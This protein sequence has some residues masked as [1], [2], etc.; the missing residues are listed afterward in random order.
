MTLGVQRIP[1][2]QFYGPNGV[3]AETFGIIPSR[4]P[5]LKKKLGDFVESEV[6]INTGILK[7]YIHEPAEVLDGGNSSGSSSSSRSVGVTSYL[8]T[9][10]TNS[11]TGG[12]GMTSYL[13]T[14]GGK[15]H[16][17]F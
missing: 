9:L 8:D 5:F 2:I 6:D 17:G 14:I 15:A 12:T 4:M 7:N 13:D 10:T 16:F 1:S 11:A 3:I